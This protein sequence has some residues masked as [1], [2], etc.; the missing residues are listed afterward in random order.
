MKVAQFA[1]EVELTVDDLFDLFS[2]QELSVEARN[3]L[4]ADSLQETLFN[5]I[6]ELC[7]R[8]PIAEVKALLEK[9]GIFGYK[10]NF[11]IRELKTMDEIGLT[12]DEIMEEFRDVLSAETLAGL[13]E[14]MLNAED[15]LGAV[16]A[17]LLNANLPAD[18]IFEEKGYHLVNY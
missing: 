7:D 15:L 3:Q 14:L 1:I 11:S 16:Y 9:K 2:L 5:I 13:S 4:R 10:Y 17:E 12:A 6:N 18:T 8:W